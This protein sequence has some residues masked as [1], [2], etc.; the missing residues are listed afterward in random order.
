MLKTAN[1]SEAGGSGAKKL[2]TAGVPATQSGFENI[3]GREN[4]FYKNAG[5]MRGYLE[6]EKSMKNPAERIY[7][8]KIPKEWAEFLINTFSD[9]QMYGHLHADFKANIICR[10]YSGKLAEKSLYPGAYDDIMHAVLVPAK[11]YYLIDPNYDSHALESILGSIRHYAAESISV[12]ANRMALEARVV[13]GINYIVPQEIIPENQMHVRLE[14]SG[15]KFV[16][17]RSEFNPENCLHSGVGS[18]II[19]KPSNGLISSAL[20]KKGLESLM[21]LLSYG[22]I[23]IHSDFSD[24]LEEAGSALLKRFESALGGELECKR[25]FDGGEIETYGARA[26]FGK[27]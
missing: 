22:G 24:R 10:A 5:R 20:P 19:K 14:A 4:P 26:Y 17:E 8:L 1:Y 9:V 16:I 7:S 2:Q 11:T 13:A 15:V 3:K 25:V 27:R 21:N 12:V 18:I 23:F 6:H